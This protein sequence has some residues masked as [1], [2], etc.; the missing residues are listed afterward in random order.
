M[1]KYIRL[2]CCLAIVFSLVFCI[3]VN[4]ANNSWPYGEEET[5]GSYRWWHNY[6]KNEMD[7]YDEPPAS[8]LMGDANLDGK[9]NA[10]DALFALNFGVNGN[11]LTRQKTA[12]DNRL[13]RP[14]TPPIVSMKSNLS[15][16]YKTGKIL[17]RI[18][19]LGNMHVYC[20]INSP[21]F[22]DVSKDCN[23]D[24]TDALMILKYAVGKSQE[25]D[26]KDFTTTSTLFCFWP[27]P[28]DYYPGIFSDYLVEPVTATDVG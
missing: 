14:K 22:A 6:C 8:P 7:N 25:F 2:L 24:A 4:A 18:G 17:D 23:V 3:P 27:W 11:L 13:P 10:V 20:A 12:S 19:T 9:I 21:F 1:K 26:T 16:A 28:T 15:T 5:L